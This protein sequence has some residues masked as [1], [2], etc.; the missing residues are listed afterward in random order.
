MYISIFR[1]GSVWLYN[2]TDNHCTWLVVFRGDVKEKNGSQE[3]MKSIKIQVEKPT[4][5]QRFIVMTTNWLLWLL[6]K[7]Y[8][9]DPEFVEKES[10]DIII[11]AIKAMRG[12]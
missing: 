5:R 4:L 7:L 9:D 6:F 12:D 3:P 10:K 2:S 11:S 1:R 8:S